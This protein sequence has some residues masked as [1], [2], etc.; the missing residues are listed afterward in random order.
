MTAAR[1]KRGAIR[2][3]QKTAAGAEHLSHRARLALLRTLKRHK[4]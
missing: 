4:R 1:L 3:L 2:L